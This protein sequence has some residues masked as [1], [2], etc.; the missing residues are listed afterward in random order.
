[1][2]SQLL[3]GASAENQV[4]NHSLTVVS[5]RGN[6]MA[7]PIKGPES[8]KGLEIGNLKTLGGESGQGTLKGAKSASIKGEMVQ[9]KTG[10]GP[11][12]SSAG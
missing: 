9:D 12:K 2:Q 7:K 11:V 1:M 6:N 10:R 3:T 8:K 4:R 5:E